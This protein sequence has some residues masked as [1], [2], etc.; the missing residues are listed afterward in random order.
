M[1]IHLLAPLNNGAA[2]RTAKKY[3]LDSMT[4]NL[5]G[6][7]RRGLSSSEH[8]VLCEGRQITLVQ[9]NHPG[10][11]AAAPPSRGQVG[12]AEFLLG[13]IT[14]GQRGPEQLLGARGAEM[15]V[16]IPA[17]PV[18]PDPPQA[19]QSPPCSPW[20]TWP[21]HPAGQ[22]DVAGMV[23]LPPWPWG[24]QAVRRVTGGTGPSQLLRTLTCCFA[25][26]AEC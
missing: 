1:E 25:F 26:I 21:S 8:I 13:R 5:M 19:P 14:P 12:I 9:T 10:A 6:A 7:V 17:V 11:G 3:P 18:P 24:C 20:G 15:G 4:E 22:T 23:A 16:P 2:A